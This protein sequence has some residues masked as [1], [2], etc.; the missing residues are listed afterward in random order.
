MITSR[1]VSQL[2]ANINERLK[3]RVGRH[4]TASFALDIANRL[5]MIPFAKS[6]L[7]H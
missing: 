2:N 3:W 6:Q 5:T 4:L 1:E 7:E